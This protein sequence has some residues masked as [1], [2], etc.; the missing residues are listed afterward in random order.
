MIQFPWKGSK[1]K[2]DV[3]IDEVLAWIKLGDDNFWQNLNNCFKVP[4]QKLM[5]LVFI[6]G[7][8]LRQ[9]YSEVLQMPWFEIEMLWKVYEEWID[10]QNKQNTLENKKYEEQMTNMKHNMP[11]QASMDRMMQNQ[12]SSF[13]MPSM[14]NL[15]MGNL[16][17]FKL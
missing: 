5:E 17:N 14:P 15:N 6:F 7:K 12:Q 8:E 2:W 10:E 9:P 11:N 4:Y 13:K 16:N 3:D 1:F